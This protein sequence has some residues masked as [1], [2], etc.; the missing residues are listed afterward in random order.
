MTS[1]FRERNCIIPI[2]NG[3]FNREP[4]GESDGLDG[5]DGMTQR[6]LGACRAGVSSA[7]PFGEAQV[8]AHTLEGEVIFVRWRSFWN[9][10][11][12]DV[13]AGS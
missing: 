7:Q 10:C 2:W 4:G 6:G 1:S 9:W 13:R 3:V 11:E 12:V 8:D 5:L